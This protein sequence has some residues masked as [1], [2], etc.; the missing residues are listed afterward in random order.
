MLPTWLPQYVDVPEHRGQVLHHPATIGVRKCIYVVAGW[1]KILR[2]AICDFSDDIR[3]NHLRLMRG[4]WDEYL[5]QFEHIE[6]LPNAYRTQGLGYVGSF[7]DLQFGISLT[8]GMRAFIEKE[9]CQRTA[10]DI[11]PV[12]VAAWNAMKGGVDITSRYLKTAQAD[13]EKSCS[14]TQRIYIKIIKM[15][16]LNAFRLRTNA[17]VFE[18]EMAG[19][20][21]SW[22]VSHCKMC[23][24]VTMHIHNGWIC[25]RIKDMRN[26]FT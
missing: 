26:A 4:I 22:Q 5:T 25:N 19:S 6:G 14:P 1:K 17:M 24:L 10:K 9:G 12:S 3:A 13:M 2:S 15:Y 18:E 11:L 23:M 20:Y 21:K 8:N 16:L 7:E